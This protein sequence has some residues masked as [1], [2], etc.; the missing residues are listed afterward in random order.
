MKTKTGS[1]IRSSTKVHLAVSTILILFG[2]GLVWAS[3]PTLNPRALYQN[4][5]QDLSYKKTQL[6]KYVSG[7]ECKSDSECMSNSCIFN[8]KYKAYTARQV[9]GKMLGNLAEMP[10]EKVCAEANCIDGIKNQDESSVDLG[11]VCGE[12]IGTVCSSDGGCNSKI[13]YQ[14]KCSS[15]DLVCN[16][17]NFDQYFETDLDCGN[18]C[19][20]CAT[21]NKCIKNSDCSISVCYQKKCLAE[22][23]VYYLQSGPMTKPGKYVDLNLGNIKTEGKETKEALQE[24]SKWIDT[25]I[26]CDDCSLTDEEKGSKTAEIMVEKKEPA[27]GCTDFGTIFVTLAR[28]KGFPTIFVDTYQLDYLNKLKSGAVP[29]DTNGHVFANVYFDGKWN[30]YDPVAKKFM[31]P[32]YNDNDCK[33]D[34][35]M[36]GPEGCYLNGKGGNY[37]HVVTNKGLDLKDIGFDNRQEA[38]LDIINQFLK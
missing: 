31:D 21:D 35:N 30:I 37:K 2:F 12:S 15:L 1:K 22:D 9:S 26:I 14:G 19:G 8:P 4:L 6:N 23:V 27:Q 7:T 28:A 10:P 20:K 11:G 38:N 5:R 25:A 33:E 3:F 29:K 34:S 13:C 17:D 16:N 24:I 36:I 18:K 32:I